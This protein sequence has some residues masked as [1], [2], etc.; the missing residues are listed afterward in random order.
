MIAESRRPEHTPSPYLTCK[1]LKTFSRFEKSLANL[2]RVR[3]KGKIFRNKDLGAIFW[4]YKGGCI[5][6]V[7]NRGQQAL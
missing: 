1:I 3:L 6:E 4:K 2:D 5:L 7:V